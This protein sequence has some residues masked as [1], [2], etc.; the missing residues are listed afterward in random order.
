[1]IIN[2][3]IAKLICEL[4]YLIGS[5][6]YNP[7]SYDGFTGEEGCDFR[8]PVYALND[9]DGRKLFKFRGNVAHSA[10]SFSSDTIHTMKYKFGANH[11]FIGKGIKKILLELE[12]RYDLDFNELE[13]LHS[14]KLKNA[15]QAEKNAEQTKE[16]H[17]QQSLHFLDIL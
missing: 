15:E 14:E 16:N 11:L 1:M 5:Q 4:E 13:R 9:G 3:Q 7:S 8:Y 10:S 6:C 2:P 12:R 17:T